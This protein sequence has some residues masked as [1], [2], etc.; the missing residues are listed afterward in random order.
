MA[1]RIK[2]ITV[3]IGGDTTG[4]EK[5][6]K[7]VNSTIKSTQSELKDVDRLLKL[8][9]SNTELLTQKQ[10]LLKDAISSTSEKL[11]TRKEAQK[12]AKEQLEN[13]ELGQDKYDALQREI[14]ETDDFEDTEQACACSVSY[15]AKESA[16]R[17]S[18]GNSSFNLIRQCRKDALN[19]GEHIRLATV[20][21]HIQTAVYLN[22]NG[23][24]MYVAVQMLH[25]YHRP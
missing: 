23:A 9:P 6:L 21:S 10:K 22:H 12:Q 18:L 15:S 25:R 5:A 11:E 2:G 13:G 14:I 3:E 19:D 16:L 1:S 20:G 7:N 8:A 24:Y 17:I 4:L